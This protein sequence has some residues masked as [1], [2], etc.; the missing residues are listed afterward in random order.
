MRGQSPSRPT[1]WADLDRRVRDAGFRQGF[2]R[3]LTEWRRIPA[4]SADSAHRGDVVRS[5]EKLAQLARDA[6]FTRAELLPT[7]GHP[8]VYAERIV[9]P[10]LPTVLVYGHYDVQPAGD[11]KEWRT[12]PFDP[13]VRGGKLFGRG[14]LDDGQLL[15]HMGAMRALLAT[16]GEMPVNVKL[17]AE[18]EEEIGSLHFEELVKRER[19]RLAADVVI[20]SDTGM[21]ERGVPSMSVSLRG[22]VYFEVQI[23]G[24]DHELH[25][26][27]FGGAVENPLNVK[28]AIMNA[29][30]DPVTK[31]VKVPGFYD[32]VTPPTPVMRRALAQLPFDAQRFREHAGNVPTL[33]GDAKRSTL[34]R[35][36]FWPTLEYNGEGGG[37]QGEGAKTIIPT[38]TT[39][40]FSTRLVKGQ[41]PAAISKAVIDHVSRVAALFPGVTVSIRELSRG[42]PVAIDPDHPAVQAAAES[43]RE[44]FGKPVAFTGEGGSIPPVT[45]L[46]QELGAPAVLVGMGLPDGRMHGPNETIDTAQ[47][48]RGIRVLGRLYTRIG[49]RM[50]RGAP[51]P[52]AATLG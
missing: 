15:M 29:L 34:E 6:G 4:V 37:Y 8:A 38:G 42:A 33:L 11:L 44:V 49:E 23:S 17:I 3:D 21:F 32:G 9:D 16:R 19:Q 48:F 46:Q 30:M 39:L 47:L 24:P 35:I 1:A 43:M 26:G 13:V 14:T 28:A 41:G 36:W 18:G 50:G 51:Q 2:L 40:K 10:K 22:L 20:V 5:A 27:E 25:S 12:P 7:S 45:V 31:E 52:Q